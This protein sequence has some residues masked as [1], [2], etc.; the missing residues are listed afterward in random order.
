MV[1]ARMCINVNAIGL[2]KFDAHKQP[3]LQIFIYLFLVW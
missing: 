2:V 1:G 3:I